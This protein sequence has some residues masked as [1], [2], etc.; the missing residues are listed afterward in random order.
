VNEKIDVETLSSEQILELKRLEERNRGTG[1]QGYRTADWMSERGPFQL[2]AKAHIYLKYLS[3][4]MDQTLIDAGAGVGRF[5]VE[6][7]PRVSRLVCQDLSSVP[8][9]KPVILDHR[10][11]EIT[12]VHPSPW[13]NRA[14]SCGFSSRSPRTAEARRAELPACSI[15]WEMRS[16]R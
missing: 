16:R 9:I 12:A 1:A 10:Q 2:W 7:A 4:R 11:G 5:A 14:R 15:V 3:P 6:V 13:C 8:C